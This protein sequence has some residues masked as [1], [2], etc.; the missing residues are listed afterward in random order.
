MRIA[1]LVALLLPSGCHGAGKASKA[2]L[3]QFCDRG[4]LA[5]D[6]RRGDACVNKAGKFK[7]CP[8][9]CA[10]TRGGG[11]RCVHADGGRWR[12]RVPCVARARTACARDGWWLEQ[13]DEDRRG[14]V[15][16]KP[17]GGWECPADCAKRNGTCL[18]GDDRMCRSAARPPR[19]ACAACAEAWDAPLTAGPKI[20]RRVDAEFV[21]S[22]CGYDLAWLGDAITELSEC[23]VDVRRT[24]VYSKCGRPPSS[25]PNGSILETL[26][27]VGR[28]DHAYA[29]HMVRR[30]DRLEPLVFFLKDSSR[31]GS[32]ADYRR[33]GVA[34][35][36][37]ARA[38]A[39]PVGFGCGRR[40]Y[41]DGSAYHWAPALLAYTLTEV[42]SHAWDQADTATR[43]YFGPFPTLGALL[44]E[45]PVLHANELERRAVVPVCYGGTFAARR[46]SVRRRARG[47][48]AAL[49]AV[50][51]RGDNILEGSMVERLW[52]ALLAPRHPDPRARARHLCA[53][54]R[55]LA[56]PHSYAGMLVGC[57]CSAPPGDVR[58]CATRHAAWRRRT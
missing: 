26:P 41:V 7:G 18:G 19:G 57:D 54:A 45:T 36:D 58:N 11:A 55:H 34:M 38:A 39:G 35:C 13:S 43:D 24:T 14:D 47:A 56:R 17:G 5:A 2:L 12:G 8:P 16:R 23:G 28:C 6:D 50:L 25:A 49:A 52:A 42:H 33:L 15:C 22:H 27:N 53:A 51:T 46:G 29:T 9:G 37:T 20:A 3:K 32:R 21:V 31:H 10:A 48:Y 44:E 1:Y 4:L 40:P 30:Y